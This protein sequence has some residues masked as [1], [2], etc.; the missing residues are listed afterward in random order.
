MRQ[1]ARPVRF[2][3]YAMINTGGVDAYEVDLV[4][5]H[6]IGWVGVRLHRRVRG[7][8]S[9]WTNCCVGGSGFVWV[10]ST[11]STTT[12]GWAWLG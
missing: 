5:R 4:G 12:Q 2:L 6:I 11:S 9:E 10:G 7:W 3:D 8:V 1:R